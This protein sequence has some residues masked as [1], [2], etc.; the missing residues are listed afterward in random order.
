MLKKHFVQ[1]FS[2]M[3]SE[4]VGSRVYHGI[5]F[6]ATYICKSMALFE[7]MA[8]AM[9]ICKRSKKGVILS[10]IRKLAQHLPKVNDTGFQM[11][12]K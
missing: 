8:S 6:I 5:A 3:Y 9:G 4:T 11:K 10:L 2:I 1:P 7:G 12:P